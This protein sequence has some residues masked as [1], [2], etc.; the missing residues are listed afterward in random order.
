MSIT[1]SISGRE[2]ELFCSTKTIMDI[3]KRTGVPFA[4]I[5]DWLSAD[6]S[7]EKTDVLSVL[8]KIGGIL[9]DL[10]NGGIFRNNCEID[11][12]LAQGEKKPYFTD[13]M[14]EGL[15]SFADITKYREKIYD[16][17]NAGM[18]VDIPE[19]IPAQDPDLADVESEK[20]A[21]AGV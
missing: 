14:I 11:L 4:Q 8:R 16:A 7:E 18:A 12:G 20:K 19:G 21:V 3:E 10:I 6:T 9:T 17:F 15:L 5:S 13:N 1:I 2:F